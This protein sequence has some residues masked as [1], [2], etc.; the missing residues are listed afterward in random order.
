MRISSTQTDEIQIETDAHGRQWYVVHGI[1]RTNKQERALDLLSMPSNEFM[2]IY[3]RVNSPA[4]VMP[5]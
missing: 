1:M 3:R 2:D 4:L 5:S